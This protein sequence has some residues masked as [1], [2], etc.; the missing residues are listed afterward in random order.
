MYLPSRFLDPGQE[1]PTQ[2]EHTGS[3]LQV[4]VA[5]FAREVPAS[6]FLPALIGVILH[7]SLCFQE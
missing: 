6:L 3:P 1:L 7:T 4:S 2:G 5:R